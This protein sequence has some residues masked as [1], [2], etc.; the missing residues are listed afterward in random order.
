[1]EALKVANKGDRILTDSQLV[2]N[3][4]MGF[5]KVKKEHLKPLVNS[6]RAIS[7]E[8]EVKIVWIPRKENLAGELFE[9]R[10]RGDSNE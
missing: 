7:R 9:K 3:Q 2:Y 5:W 4:V 6:A 1:M 10:K 8:K